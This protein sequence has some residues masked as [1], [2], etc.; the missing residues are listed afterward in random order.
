MLKGKLGLKVGLMVGLIALMASPALARS[1][2]MK[3]GGVALWVFLII[4]AG[5]VLLQLIPA[6]ILFFSFIGTTTT[7]VFKNGKKA[8][9]EAPF[10]ETELV[11][12]KK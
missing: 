3:E 2:S 4:G 1:V 7:M 12:V 11:R 9:E 6:M 8:K 10:P 5:I